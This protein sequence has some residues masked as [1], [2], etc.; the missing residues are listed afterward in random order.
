[1]FKLALMVPLPLLILEF[2]QHH[3][4]IEKKLPKKYQLSYKINLY[5]NKTIK[6]FKSKVI[7]IIYQTVFI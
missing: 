5:I 1:M 3:T 7:T 2:Q 6:I 4:N